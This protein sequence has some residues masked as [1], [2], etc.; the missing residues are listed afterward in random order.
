MTGNEVLARLSAALAS[1]AGAYL[2]NPVRVG[3]RTCAVCATPVSGRTRCHKCDLHHHHDGRADATAFLTY[4][5]SGQQSGYVM[6]GYKAPQPLAEHRTVVTLLAYVGLAR[7]A[8]CAPRLAGRAVTHW[9]TVPSLPAKPGPHPFHELIAPLAPGQEICLEAAACVEYARAVRPDHFGVA[10]PRPEGAHVLLLDDTWTSG[11]HAQSAALTL[12]RA[13]AAW[14]SL[15]V[16]A[17]WISTDYGDNR[18]F[19]RQLAARDYDPGRCPWTGG[20]CPPSADDSRANQVAT[21]RL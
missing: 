7:H 20:P 4:A 6:R 11:G 12:H 13:G 8:R 5:V 18:G 1:R 10:G 3:G 16:A 19:L 2:Y 9:A 17:R 15:L 21:E 14:V